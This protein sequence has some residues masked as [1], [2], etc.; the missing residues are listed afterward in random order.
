MVVPRVAT[1]TIR[2][3]KLDGESYK[4]DFSVSGS[5]YTVV[6]ARNEAEARDVFS[7]GKWNAHNAHWWESYVIDEIT[8]TTEEELPEVPVPPFP[9]AV[10]ERIK[11]ISAAFFAALKAADVACDEH[12]MRLL[13]TWARDEAKWQEQQSKSVAP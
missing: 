2:E 8:E 1:I 13:A 11:K 3:F 5:T 6:R 9:P 7:E 4:I 12:V 10:E